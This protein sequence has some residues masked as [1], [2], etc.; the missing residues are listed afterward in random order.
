MTAW[1]ESVESFGS[2]IIF[3]S[4]T[5]G[6]PL[7]QLMLLTFLQPTNYS[8]V[9]KILYELFLQFVMAAGSMAWPIWCYTSMFRMGSNK[10]FIKDNLF[11]TQKISTK[12]YFP[13]PIIRPGQNCRPHGF[14]RQKQISDLVIFSDPMGGKNKRPCQNKANL[15]GIWP[16]QKLATR[17]L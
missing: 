12:D 11:L 10:P 15:M 5:F 7:T 13:L 4:L 9:L 6:N 14:F 17:V 16:P 8:M 2:G 1:K 3:M